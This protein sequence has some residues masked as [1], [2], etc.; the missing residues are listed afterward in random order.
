MNLK[1]LFE[2]WGLKGLKVKT[3]ILEMDFQPDDAD[4]NAAWEMYIELLTRITTQRLQDEHGIESAALK[5]IHDIFEITRDVLKRNGRGCVNFTKIAIIVLNQIIRPFT[6]KWHK[7]SE[8][9]VFEDTDKCRVFR[10]ELNELQKKL[11]IYTKLLSELADV[12]DMT[13]MEDV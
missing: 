11:I 13:E 10:K 4:K 3:P 8:E 9:G 2:K 5:S 1:N 7:L 12:E 6:A